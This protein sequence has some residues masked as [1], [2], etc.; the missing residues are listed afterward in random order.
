MGDDI[1]DRL[2]RWPSWRMPRAPK[3]SR[4]APASMP[5]ANA[6]A[7]G[8]SASKNWAIGCAMASLA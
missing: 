4:D 6:A 7:L 3:A 1:T 8:S 2:T 5:V